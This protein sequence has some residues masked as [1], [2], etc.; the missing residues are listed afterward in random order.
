MKFKPTELFTKNINIKSIDNDG[1]YQHW[2]IESITY[3]NQEIN[4]GKIVFTQAG[5]YEIE[6]LLYNEKNSQRI[7]HIIT[8]YAN[9]VYPKETKIIIYD[10]W[11]EFKT[12]TTPINHSL[13]NTSITIIG[14]K[15]GVFITV[16]EPTTEQY[17]SNTIQHIEKKYIKKIEIEI[18]INGV[19]QFI[20]QKEMTSENT[21]ITKTFE[22]IEGSLEEINC[23]L[24]FRCQDYNENIVEKRL[25][26][27]LH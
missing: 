12:S 11:L 20:T 10:N 16:Y 23:I 15:S 18:Q 25:Q 21:S 7:S 13:F 8:I 14:I 22:A 1:N 2:S 24:I 6:L 26:I 17:P 19:S 4:T 3:L 27:Q 9:N 5:I